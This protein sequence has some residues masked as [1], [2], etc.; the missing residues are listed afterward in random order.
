MKDYV[1]LMEMIEIAGRIQSLKER[2]EELKALMHTK[3]Y[4]NLNAAFHQAEKVT[5]E[6][7]TE[8]AEYTR[9]RQKIKEDYTNVWAL[10]ALDKLARIHD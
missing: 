10:A 6:I 1:I 3:D 4:I 7:L 2:A 8:N 5:E 9:L